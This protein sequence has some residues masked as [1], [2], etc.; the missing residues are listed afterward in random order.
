MS[1]EKKSIILLDIYNLLRAGEHL[2]REAFIHE[3]QISVQTYYRYLADIKAYLKI[4]H[5]SYCL[6]SDKDKCIYLTKV[7]K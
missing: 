5:V 3:H 2:N 4:Y 7:Q 1:D 6:L